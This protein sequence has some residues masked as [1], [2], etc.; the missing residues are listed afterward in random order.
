MVYQPAKRGGGCP[1]F[2]THTHLAPVL[3]AELQAAA[4][5]TAGLLPRDIVRGVAA[6]ATA[7]AAADELSLDEVGRG[8]TAQAMTNLP[9][10]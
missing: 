6:D 3:Q 8:G 7:A 2:H 4:Q 10:I 1:Y 5:A 9:D